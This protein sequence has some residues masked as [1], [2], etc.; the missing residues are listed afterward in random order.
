MAPESLLIK[1]DIER[2][3]VLGS[4]KD[5]PGTMIGS[6]ALESLLNMLD[7]DRNSVFFF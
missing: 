2:G 5:R 3:V 7:I 1:S 4:A 6:M